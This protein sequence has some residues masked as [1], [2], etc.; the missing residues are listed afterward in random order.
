MI[1]DKH[2]NGLNNEIKRR[3]EFIQKELSYLDHQSK[4]RYVL[5]DPDELLKIRSD[6]EK[7]C[8]EM[9]LLN[10][11]SDFYAENV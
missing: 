1:Q 3:L 6:F 9:D 10:A 4:K 5:N 2:I 8:V 11:L 7:Y